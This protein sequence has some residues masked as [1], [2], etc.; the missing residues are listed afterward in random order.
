M[1]CI[2]DGWFRE[3]NEMWSGYCVSLQIEEILHQEKSKFQEILV[4]KR[5]VGL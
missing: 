3:I 2:E 1:S 4:F 5:Y